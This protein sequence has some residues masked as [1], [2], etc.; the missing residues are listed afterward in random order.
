MGF[1]ISYL[2]IRRFRRNKVPI[3]EP[4]FLDLNAQKK[5]DSAID[6][7]NQ[8]VGK[9][10]AGELNLD[11]FERLFPNYRIGRGILRILLRHFYSFTSPTMEEVVSKT[12]LTLLRKQGLNDVL[13]FR[14]D[15]YRWLNLQ[16]H[17]FSQKKSR[18]KT[19]REYAKQLGISYENPERLIYLDRQ[20]ESVLTVI[21]V[22]TSD[23]VIEL[24]NY[25]ILDT[26]LRNT[27]RLSFQVN[28]PLTGTLIKT[29]CFLCKQHGILYDI[30]MKTDEQ[31]VINLEGPFRVFGRITRYS[32]NI[33]SVT[34]HLLDYLQSSQIPW[35]LDAEVILY[36]K[37]YHF[38]LSE[39]ILPQIALY[40]KYQGVLKDTSPVY[41]SKIEHVVANLF[42]RNTENWTLINEPRP[43]THSG[44]V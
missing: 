6:Y 34:F 17:G 12:D 40:Q 33:A 22:C 25:N 24:Y 44:I 32:E 30:L 16:G 36:D 8:Y 41:D 42:R 19:I 18:R 23:Q 28:E 29:L 14:L 21:D 31:L 38:Y 10:T 15:F 3:V 43:I 9:T 37:K 11:W 35:E 1:A 39:T 7:L 2:S 27:L 5:I 13:N 4:K 26:M 20:E